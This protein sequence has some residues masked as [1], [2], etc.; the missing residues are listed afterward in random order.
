MASEPSGTTEKLEN[1]KN[2][3]HIE[4]IRIVSITLYCVF[5]IDKGTFSVVSNRLN[6]T[7]DTPP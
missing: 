6:D 2:T 1:I 5:Q 4:C 3:Y 7:L